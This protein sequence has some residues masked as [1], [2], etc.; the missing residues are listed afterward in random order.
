MDYDTSSP[1][2]LQVIED[3][4]RKLVL[5]ELS[6]GEQLPSTRNLALMY[7]INPNTCAR[8][9]REMELLGLCYTKRGLGTFITE[10]DDLVKTLRQDM[11][12]HL[13]ENFTEKMLE[14]GYSF[15]DMIEIIKS[16]ADL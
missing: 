13:I 8:I 10:S 1:I 16:K 6:I 15:K 3:I 5:G 12:N 14:L 9:Y 11:A 7:N 4:K 2:Y